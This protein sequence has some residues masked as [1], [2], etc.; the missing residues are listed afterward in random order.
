MYELGYFDYAVVGVFS[1]VGALRVAVADE[2]R[3]V[4]GYRF[5]TYEGGECLLKKKLTVDEL[6]RETK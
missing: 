1:W 6:I 2:R 5:V 3:R 4:Y